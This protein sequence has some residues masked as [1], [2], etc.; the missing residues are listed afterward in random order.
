MLTGIRKPY[1]FHPI[2]GEEIEGFR[3][4]AKIDGG[5]TFLQN[6]RWSGTRKQTK[7]RGV[8]GTVTKS[9]PVRERG[10]GEI[11]TYETAIDR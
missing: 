5:R 9:W 1:T 4:I 2:T 8:R 7:A 10:T 11:G 3:Q 6:R